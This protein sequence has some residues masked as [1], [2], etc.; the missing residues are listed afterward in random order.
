VTSRDVEAKTAVVTSPSRIA[1]ETGVK[2]LKRGGNAID[3]AVATA[4]ALSVVAPGWSGLGGGGFIVAYLSNTQETVAI[5]YRETA[6]AHVQEYRLRSDGKV[7]NDANSI[8]HKAVA[9]PGTLAGLSLAL[10]DYGT[11]SLKEIIEPT[12]K[13]AKNGFEVTRFW[14]RC[15]TNNLSGALNKI[16]QFPETAKTLTKNGHVYEFGKNMSLGDLGQ[17]FAKIAEVGPQVF[18]GGE[19]AEIIAADMAENDGWITE[20]DL[21]R[22]KAETRKPIVG[23]YRDYEI[24]SMPPPSSGANLIQIL[25]ILEDFDLK[26]L[27]HNSPQTIHLMAEAIRLAFTDRKKYVA[28]P[29][30][31][32]TPI[33]KLTSKDHAEK[34]RREINSNKAT[35]STHSNILDEEQVGNTAHVSVIDGDGN[36]VSLTESLE[37]FLGSGVTI[38]STGLLMNDEMHDFDLD[39]KSPNC[40]KPDKRPVSNMA[41]TIIMK[42]GSPSMVLGSA[43]GQ[44][45]ITS[46]IQVIVNII[47]FNMMPQKAIESP[48]FSCQHGTVYVETR[49]LENVRRELKRKGHKIIAGSPARSLEWMPK[50]YNLYYGAVQVVLLDQGKSKVYGGADPRQDSGAVGY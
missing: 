5:D 16:S 49:I 43:G 31:V 2:I 39:A 24:V 11:M 28:D 41:P 18:Y 35:L 37:C 26:K 17:T 6:P 14:H 4:F 25:N 47:D 32:S 10:D 23:A 19:V 44:S 9:V 46:I 33:E 29:D 22:Y 34:L 7:E 40:I 15:V 3:A 50:G 13:Y 8:G 20:E 12:I 21:V 27:G 30:F 36:M 42:D 1:S 48:R 45:I 38:P